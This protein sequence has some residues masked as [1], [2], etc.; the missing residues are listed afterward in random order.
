MNNKNQLQVFLAIHKT[1]GWLLVWVIAG[2]LVQILIWM[3]A[4]L[5]GKSELFQTIIDH[6]TLP[7]SIRQ[8]LYRPWSIAT[9]AFFW[10]LGQR[11]LILTV[12]FDT[13]LVW[14]FT[15]SY[16]QLLGEKHTTR[17]IILA[18]PLIALLASALSALLSLQV[19]LPTPDNSSSF[20]SGIT[21]LMIFMGVALAFFTP[22]YPMQIILL[23]PVKIKWIVLVIFVLKFGAELPLHSGASVA[24]PTF[25]GLVILSSGLLAALHISLLRNGKDVTSFV[26]S[27]YQD[28]YSKGRTY[29]PKMTVKHGGKYGKETEVRKNSSRDGKI[30]QEVVDTILDK[31]SEKGYESLS[32]EEK[33]LLFKASKQKD[34]K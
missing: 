16:R 7:S 13:M 15:Q 17:I 25:M 5:A 34:D 20:G 28:K 31:I 2:L 3:G 22:N 11:E 26:W 14:T 19:S 32:R 21:A 18:I 10:N 29:A 30:S 24:L 1:T 6:L 33:E 27:Y 4:S 12:L 8:L 23:G 9:Y